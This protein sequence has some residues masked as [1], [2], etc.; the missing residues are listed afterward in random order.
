MLIIKKQS[1]NEFCDIRVLVIHSFMHVTIMKVILLVQSVIM[2][3]LLSIRIE[4]NIPKSKYIDSE[5]DLRCHYYST[6]LQDT[7]AIPTLH[8]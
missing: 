7:A 1:M 3:V 8:L 5:F 6:T 2:F 4:N